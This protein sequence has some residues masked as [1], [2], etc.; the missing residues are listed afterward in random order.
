[1]PAA[2]TGLRC[3]ALINYKEFFP[4][5]QTLIFKHPHKTVESPI[6]I[7]HTVAIPP[8]SFFLVSLV[9]FFRKD[10]LP[11]GKI[12]DHHSPFSQSVRDKIRCFVQ[13][14]LLLVTL[15][16]RDALIYLR[17]MDIPT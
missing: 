15:L 12:A 4:I 6:I 5:E 7:Y 8:L 3:I 17:E 1:M 10:R 14:V 9:L 16:F 11:L 2:V 13:T